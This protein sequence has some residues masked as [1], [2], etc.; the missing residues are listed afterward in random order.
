MRGQAFLMKNYRKENVIITRI[1]HCRLHRPHL[2]LKPH[3]R[4]Q[5]YSVI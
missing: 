5:M 1:F 4:Q 3:G 2:R